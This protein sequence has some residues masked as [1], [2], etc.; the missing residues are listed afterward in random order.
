M[1]AAIFGLLGVIVG[2]VLNGVVFFVLERRK[3]ASVFHLV[4]AELPLLGRAHL[5]RRALEGEDATGPRGAL[6]ASTRSRSLS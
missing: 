3:E 1:T 2:G 5:R 4:A 6:S